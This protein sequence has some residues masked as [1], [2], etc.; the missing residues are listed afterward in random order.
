MICVT[1]GQMNID[2]GQ[3]IFVQS[4]VQKSQTGSF[5]VY[6][7]PMGHVKEPSVTQAQING[8]LPGKM[9]DS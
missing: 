1:S 2:S 5:D 9:S 3:K 6:E 7:A 8:P 4:Q